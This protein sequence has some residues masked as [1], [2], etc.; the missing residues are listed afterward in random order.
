[1]KT[2]DIRWMVATLAGTALLA[3]APAAPAKYYGGGGDNG[4]GRARQTCTPQEIREALASTS[5]D[6]DASADARFRTDDRCRLDFRVEVEDVPVG[7]YTLAVGGVDR[8]TIA[9]RA[10]PMGTGGKIEFK[11]GDD[12]GNELPLDFDPL[13]ATIEIRSAETIFFSALFDG[14]ADGGAG[15]P[16]PTRTA[17]PSDPPATRTPTALRTPT[18]GAT[19]AAT[20]TRIDDR[21]RNRRGRGNGRIGTSSL[22]AGGSIQV[23]CERRANR[24]R[25]SVD[26]K[27]LLSGSYRAQVSSGANVAVS[28]LQATVGDEV[29]LDF[30]SAPKDIA[31]GATAIA[32]TF[33][34]GIPAQ[35][36]ATILDSSG[37]TVVATTATCRTR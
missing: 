25:I 14:V 1:M 3:A 35:V 30:D 36:T 10:T 21:G 28:G 13:G 16:T 15:T 12:D 24:S 6:A 26:G 11:A 4:G 2:Q 18:N 5:A 23:K 17:V 32:A 8:G 33:I 31:A 7:D 37:N 9:V 29:E 19:P 22:L 34:Q 20:R 27:D